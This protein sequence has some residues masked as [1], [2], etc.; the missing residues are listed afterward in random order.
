MKDTETKN[1][2]EIN[3]I[4]SQ[5]QFQQTT[6]TSYPPPQII[7]SSSP[8]NSNTMDMLTR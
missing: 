2:S 1:I 4:K 8:R 3:R 6:Y 5:Q 7:T